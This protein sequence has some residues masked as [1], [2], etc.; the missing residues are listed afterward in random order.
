MKIRTEILIGLLI[1]I[2]SCDTGTGK[3]SNIRK[4]D[5][6]ENVKTDNR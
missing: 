2:I 6:Q 1:F 4:D 3:K 5:S